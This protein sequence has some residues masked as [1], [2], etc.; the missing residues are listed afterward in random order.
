MIMNDNFTIHALRR[1]FKG[2]NYD[3]Y[4]ALNYKFLVVNYNNSLRFNYNAHLLK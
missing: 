2:K 3:N 4:L 1:Y